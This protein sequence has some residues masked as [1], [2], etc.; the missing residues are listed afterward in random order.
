MHLCSSCHQTEV[1]WYLGEDCSLQVLKVGLYAGLGTVAAIVVITIAFLTA[2]LVI[3]KR[4]VK[5]NKD[6]KQEL[7]KEW[8][9]DD[10]EWPPQKKTS[11]GTYDNPEYS[12]RQDSLG[13]TD[14]SADRFYTQNVSPDPVPLRYLQRNQPL[15]MDRPQIRS[16]FEI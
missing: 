3:T 8:L 2:Y 14:F 13:R 12:Q 11:A 15:K 4:T 9:N 1:K 6:I 16:S 7:V 5:R 10:F